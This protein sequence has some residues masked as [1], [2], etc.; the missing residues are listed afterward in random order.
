MPRAM[1]RGYSLFLLRSI[2]RAISPLVKIL[3]NGVVIKI[4]KS[5][6]TLVHLLMLSKILKNILENLK[7]AGTA[8]HP[9]VCRS[10]GKRYMKQYRDKFVQY[11]PALLAEITRLSHGWDRHHLKEVC[12]HVWDS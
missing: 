5:V 2:S 3:F 6:V 4:I 10:T 7:P 9:R 12:I 1:H 8:Y 11:F